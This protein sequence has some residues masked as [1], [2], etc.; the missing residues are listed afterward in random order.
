VGD[1]RL[2]LE[3]IEGM[4]QEPGP[5][6]DF[7]ALTRPQMDVSTDELK[8]ME[9]LAPDS[10]M[11]EFMEL[12]VR[13]VT[14]QFGIPKEFGVRRHGDL[15]LSEV[16]FWKPPVTERVLT[17]QMIRDLWDSHMGRDAARP[18]HQP[19]P[20]YVRLHP[21]L[22]EFFR[23]PRSKKGDAEFTAYAKKHGMRLMW[24]N[25]ENRIYAR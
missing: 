2:W 21:G 6:I 22:T 18:Y 19:W 4:E 13:K 25:Y 16:A 1:L 3:K 15:W 24:A 9:S 12:M 10:G 17:F 8:F 5:R 20:R 7:K 23:R 11:K 14:A